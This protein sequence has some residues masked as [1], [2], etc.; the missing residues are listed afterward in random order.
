MSGSIGYIRANP[1][2]QAF[3][4]QVEFQGKVYGTQQQRGVDAAIRAGV[5]DMLDRGG[6]AYYQ[7]PEAPV[8]PPAAP[9]AAPP[10]PP[11]PQPVEPPSP[12]VE[13]PAVDV[14]QPD[15]SDEGT[16]ALLA[17]GPDA[18]KQ[19]PDESPAPIGAAARSS[20]PQPSAFRS[21][22]LPAPE[23]SMP[24]APNGSF[25]ARYDPILRQLSGTPGGG[26]PALQILGQQSR[27]DMGMLKR[28]DTYQ[29]LAML[30]FG[31]G[32]TALGQYYARLGGVNVPPEIASNAGMARRLGVASLLAERLYNGDAAAAQRF[33]QGF[34]GSGDVGAAFE[35]A[36]PPSTNPHL[37]I[38]QVYDEATNTLRLYGISTQGMSAGQAVPIM[39]PGGQQLV[40]SPKPMGIDRRMAALRAA[41]FSDQDAA[42]IASGASTTPN[43]RLNAYGRAVTEIMRQDIEGKLSPQEVAA[44]AKALVEGAG[45]PA[46]VPAGVGSQPVPAAPAPAPATQPQPAAPRPPVEVTAPPGLPPGSLYS[47]SRR[48]WR[49]PAGHLYDQDGR[50]LTGAALAPS[51]SPFGGT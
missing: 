13:Q 19:G 22:G 44:R 14:R 3:R 8:E 39:T 21:V 20:S 43:A 41:G 34:I 32:D 28:G 48:Q 16:N 26:A 7:P 12:P 31:K 50:R 18:L 40:G 46:P 23:A 11:A 15:G 47:P 33:V 24:G 49:D 10:A 36:G 25:N 45:M 6:S 4:D 35:Q 37:S 2:T 29:R 1:A 9:A 42:L 30:A 5:A 51:A 38:Q 27:W 17:A